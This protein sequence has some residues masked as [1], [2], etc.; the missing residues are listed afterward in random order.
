MPRKRV[1]RLRA[2]FKCFLNERIFNVEFSDT[3]AIKLADRY[4]NLYMI[5]KGQNNRNYAKKAQITYF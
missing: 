4:Q 3:N 5:E 2:I 1:P